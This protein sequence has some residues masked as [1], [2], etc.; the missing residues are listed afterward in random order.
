MLILIVGA[1]SAGALLGAI[2]RLPLLTAAVAA[3]LAAIAA[4]AW[5]GTVTELLPTMAA[6]AGGLQFGYG[7]VVVLRALAG[8]R[9]HEDGDC[10]LS[11]GS[12]QPEADPS[13]GAD[14]RQDRC[15]PNQP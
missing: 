3:A 10:R 9:T 4:C 14:R 2:A 13:R 12:R 5:A 1:V 11:D 8:T 6:L 7:A 15:S